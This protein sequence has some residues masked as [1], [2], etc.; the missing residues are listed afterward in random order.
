MK[1]KQ[2]YHIVITGPKSDQKII[3]TKANSLTQIHDLKL[4]WLGTVISIEVA[5]LDFNG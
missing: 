3:E 1:K 2:K 5:G 4:S